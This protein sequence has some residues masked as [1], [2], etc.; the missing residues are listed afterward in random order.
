MKLYVSGAVHA[1]FHSV[2]D[3]FHWLE[4]YRRGRTAQASSQQVIGALARLAM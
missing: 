4:G 3:V 1:E 2:R